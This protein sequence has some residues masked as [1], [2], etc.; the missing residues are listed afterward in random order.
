MPTGGD[1]RELTY[2]HPTLGSGTIFLKGGEDTTVDLGGL[3]S[4]DDMGMIDTGGNM[5]DKMNIT[6]WSFEATVSWDMNIDL[7][8]DKI[9][10]LSASPVLADWTMS[11]T[12]GTVFGGKGKPVGDLKGNANAATFPLKLS[13]GGE[14]KK[15]I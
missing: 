5:I 12:N 1:F 4:A 9:K 2:N 8:L 15:I 6:R 11:H 3:R 10:A 13:G 14:L 7:T